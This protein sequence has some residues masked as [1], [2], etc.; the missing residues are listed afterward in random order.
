[1]QSTRLH[2]NGYL[3]KNPTRRELLNA[4]R[5]EK[6][7]VEEQLHQQHLELIESFGQLHE[8]MTTYEAEREAERIEHARQIDELKKAREADL[9]ALRQEFL[10]MMQAAHGQTTF[11]QVLVKPVFEC[12][13]FL[14]YYIYLSACFI[15][16]PT[17]ICP[18]KQ[19]CH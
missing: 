5:L 3:A 1:M 11:E 13:F 14:R 15:D 17:N 9:Q 10:S 4:D 12:L 19:Q 18:G 8:Q 7:H 6:I 16:S 2:D